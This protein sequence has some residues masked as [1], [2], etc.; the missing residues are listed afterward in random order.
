MK[1]RISLFPFIKFI[2]LAALML[3]ACSTGND[4]IIVAAVAALLFLAVG[5]HSDNLLISKLMFAGAVLGLIISHSVVRLVDT[6]HHKGRGFMDY[7]SGGYGEYGGLAGD[8]SN[9]EPD[10]EKVSESEYKRHEYSMNGMLLG[11]GVMFWF[12]VASYANGI[13]KLEKEK[14]ERERSWIR[15]ILNPI[16]VQ[17]IRRHPEHYRDDFKQ[18]IKEIQPDLLLPAEAAPNT[19]P[20]TNPAA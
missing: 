12:W 19:N 16:N 8:D 7:G 4:F 11:F 17:E 6:A 10:V 15:M 9:S 1:I 13:N 20:P 14:I 5:D 18:W 3:A 2:G